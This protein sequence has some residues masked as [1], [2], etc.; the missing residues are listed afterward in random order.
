MVGAERE[1]GI[2]W[3]C[4]QGRLAGT[5]DGRV[6]GWQALFRAREGC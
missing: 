4:R 6:A 5:L 2:R 1:V 3:K